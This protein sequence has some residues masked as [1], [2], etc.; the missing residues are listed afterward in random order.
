MKYFFQCSCNIWTLYTSQYKCLCT[1]ILLSLCSR[2][3]R[4]Y[5]TV[6]CFYIFLCIVVLLSNYLHIWEQ[7]S[8]MFYFVIFQIPD[9]PLYLFV[10]GILVS[11][12]TF[13]LPQYSN[14]QYS[15]PPIHRQITPRGTLKMNIKKFIF[16]WLFYEFHLF[17]TFSPNLILRI[18]PRS[19]SPPTASI[20]WLNCRSKFKKFYKILFTVNFLQQEVWNCTSCLQILLQKNL[21]SFLA[22]NS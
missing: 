12:R 7:K 1:A 20:S 3:V 5:F 17:W 4:L 16:N 11:K 18:V 8:P 9:R 2:F 19:P 10:V 13:G 21:N 6:K 14:N 22:E 15:P